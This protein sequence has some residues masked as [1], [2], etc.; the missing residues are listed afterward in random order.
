MF[1]SGTTERTAWACWPKAESQGG[2]GVGGNRRYLTQGDTVQRIGPEISIG[3]LC[4]LSLGQLAHSVRS[5]AMIEMDHPPALRS[6]LRR[7]VRDFFLFHGRWDCLCGV[8]HGRFG[9]PRAS[10]GVLRLIR[11]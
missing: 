2:P 4:P 3:T 7:G 1:R 9:V 5:V 6:F 11:H 10:A 8:G